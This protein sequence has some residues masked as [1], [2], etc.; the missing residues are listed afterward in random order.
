MCLGETFTVSVLK[1][2]SCVGMSLCRLCATTAFEGRGGFA[3]MPVISFLTVCWQLSPWLWM[4]GGDGE[5]KT[6]AQ[7]EAG[8]PLC[9]VA[10]TTLPGV[11]SAP[12]L[13]E[14]KPRGSGLSCFFPL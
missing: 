3:L 8:V 13:L 12:K 1:A 14:H 6:W 4:W 7:C 9:L 10:I 5:A 11:R 2:C